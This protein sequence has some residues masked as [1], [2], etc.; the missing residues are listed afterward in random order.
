VNFYSISMQISLIMFLSLAVF[1]V[2]LSHSRFSSCLYLIKIYV[3]SCKWTT[4]QCPGKLF[5]TGNG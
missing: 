3:K 2:S 4:K 5:W 1:S